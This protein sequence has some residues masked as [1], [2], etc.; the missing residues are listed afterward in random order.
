[1]IKNLQVIK[2]KIESTRERFGVE[3][4][5]LQEKAFKTFSKSMATPT[6]QVE[7]KRIVTLVENSK[8]LTASESNEWLSQWIREDFHALIDARNTFEQGLLKRY[9]QENHNVDID[10]KNDVALY[11]IGPCIV[12]DSESGDIYDQDSSKAVIYRDQYLRDDRTED[13]VKRNALIE[14]HMEKTGYFPSVVKMDRYGNAVYIDTLSPE[15]KKV[16]A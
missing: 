2:A 3:L 6:M 7:V 15:A 8:D 12:I 5:E 1:M 10:F 4:Q 13:H 9:F 16:S 11:D 14:A